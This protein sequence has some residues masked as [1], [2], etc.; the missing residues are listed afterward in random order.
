MTVLGWVTC[1]LGFFWYF[2]MTLRPNKFVQT[3]SID[4]YGLE[5]WG[6]A[7]IPQAQR[8]LSVAIII[9]AIF[10]YSYVGN[11]ASKP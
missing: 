5:K 11:L 8:I 10:Y 9:M 7:P 2:Y 4:E 1:G 3:I 6:L